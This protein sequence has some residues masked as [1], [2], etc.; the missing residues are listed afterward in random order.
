MCTQEKQSMGTEMSFLLILIP[1]FAHS[2]DQFNWLY[3]FLLLDQC[4]QNWKII[5]KVEQQIDGKV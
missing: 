3:N 1:M 2:N 5:K 4:F